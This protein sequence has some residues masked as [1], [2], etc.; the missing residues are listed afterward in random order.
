MRK[1]IAILL[2]LAL[3]LTI[4]CG[5]MRQAADAPADTEKVAVSAPVSDSATASAVTDVDNELSEIDSVDSELSS[6]E[7]DNL[8]SE[9]NFEI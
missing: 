7:L 1:L 6:E 9:L 3:L 2:V 5:G 8:D 4:G